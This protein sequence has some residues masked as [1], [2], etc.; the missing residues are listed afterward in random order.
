MITEGCT[1]L[2]CCPRYSFMQL[3]SCDSSSQRCLRF[4]LFDVRC[5]AHSLTKGLSKTFDISSSGFL[6]KSSMI[7]KST[8][9]VA[10]LVMMLLSYGS[11]IPW[12]NS[13][14]C[15]ILHQHTFRHIDHISTI[16]VTS[17]C[18]LRWSML[19]CTPAQSSC[20][21]ELYQINWGDSDLQKSQTVGSSRSRDLNTFLWNLVCVINVFNACQSHREHQGTTEHTV[22]SLSSSQ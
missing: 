13:T 21:C 22:V 6:Y 14:C 15:H 18:E 4:K 20:F 16:C 1:A 17:L 7:F 5:V 9:T 19:H 10:S 12:N 8:N 3:I 11:F 2:F